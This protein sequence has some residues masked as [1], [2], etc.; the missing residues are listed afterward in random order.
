[1]DSPEPTDR[2]VVDLRS[3]TVTRPTPAMRRAIAAAEVGDDALG[4]DPTT[5]RLEERVARLLGKEAALFF[6]SGIMANQTALAVLGTWGGEVV[7]DAG[8]HI[9]H[10]EEGAPAAL[11]G[12]QLRPVPSEGGLLSPEDVEGAIRKG[13][14]YYP[15]SCI[16]A[17]ENTH[18][19][20]GGRVFPLDRLRAV[21]DVAARHGLPVHLD[22]A[23]LW[24]ASVETGVTPEEY[25]RPV[26]TVMV[27]FSKGLG[28]PVGSAL[29]GPRA[30]IESAWR[31]R[32]RLGG[33]MR[34]SGIL[35]AAALHALDHH[36]ERLA[37]DHANARALAEAFDR[38]PGFRAQR[39]ETNIVLVQT[40]PPKSDVPGLLAFLEKRSILMLKFGETRLR[41][42]THLDA[43]RAGIL[44]VVNALDDWSSRP[45]RSG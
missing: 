18:L 19:D 1:V 40:D 31:V 10:Y 22:G 13:S 26:T 27:S 4:D 29:A 7:L 15:R 37:E 36:V 2:A 5:R 6:P 32:R 45:S 42:V 38:I 11:S 28:A 25:C 3:D 9:L 34:Q 33:G 20:S 8:A 41:A 23:R 44:R 39:P 35:T 16:V 30:V 12:L 21:A 24:H 17:L 14:R 43:D